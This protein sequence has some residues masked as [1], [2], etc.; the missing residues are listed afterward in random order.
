MEAGMAIT[1]CL[2]GA[3]TDD[4]ETQ[5]NQFVSKHSGPIA[6]PIGMAHLLRDILRQDLL[7]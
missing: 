2:I 5:P 7:V 4:I 6:T 3:V 1:V